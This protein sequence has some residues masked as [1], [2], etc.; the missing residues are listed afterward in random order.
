[1]FP[2]TASAGCRPTSRRRFPDRA[3]RARSVPRRAAD[4]ARAAVAAFPFEE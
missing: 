4:P 1:M 3:P 2:R